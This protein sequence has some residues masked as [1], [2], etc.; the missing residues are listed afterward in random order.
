MKPNDGPVASESTSVI[1]DRDVETTLSDGTILRSDLYRSGA[2]PKPVILLRTPYDKS[3]HAF[4]FS[5][6]IDPIRAAQS[7]Y[8]VLFQDVRGRYASDGE[9]HPFVNERNDGAETIDWIAMQ[10]WSDGNVLTTGASYCGATQ[11]LAASGTP[12]ALRAMFPIVTGSDYAEGWTYQGGAVQLGFVYFWAL[13]SLVSDHVARRFTGES[14]ARYTADALRELDTIDAGYLRLPAWEQPLFAEIGLEFWREWFANG[15]DDAYWS[16][17]APNRHYD[18]I[19]APGHHM[20][21][22]F[23]IFLEGTLENY[24]ELSKRHPGNRLIVGPWTHNGWG[25]RLPNAEYGHRAS[26]DFIDLDGLQ[27]AY[28]DE[29][30]S[31]LSLAPRTPVQ[32]F[33]MGSN[34]WRDEESWPLARAVEQKLYLNSDGTL[35]T[36]LSM[37]A[38]SLDYRYRP[39]DPVPTLGGPT[40]MPGPE[41][42]ANAGPRDHGAPGR[43]ADVLSFQTAALRTALEVTGQITAE[44][45][46]ALSTPSA[47]VVVRALDVHPDGRAM[48]LAE[49]ISRVQRAGA[50]QTVLVT[51]GSTS[52]TFLPGHRIRIDVTSSSFPRFDRNP[53]ELGDGLGGREITRT[54]VLG[55]PAAA[56]VTFPTIDGVIDDARL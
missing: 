34:V 8:H 50:R 21:G 19:A 10:P 14:A 22:W 54:L 37:D 5:G 13:N 24:A 32:L 33:I 56:S 12:A 9:F 36:E 3:A 35:T 18:R 46:T 6:A 20:G 49:G 45:V 29:V 11:L 51:V 30:L 48:L 55:G 15:P 26:R 44:I 1:I 43:R 40:L 27:L 31:G 25:D 28:F 7:G 39:S 38:T 47:D 23:D 4:A 53:D 42:S 41:I 17:L 16:E 52:N 2:E